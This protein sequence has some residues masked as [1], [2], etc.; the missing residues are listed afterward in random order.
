MRR[1]GVSGRGWAFRLAAVAVAAGFVLINTDVASR[2]GVM[3]GGDTPRY[4]NGADRL[5]A[6]DGLGHQQ[7]I[8]SGYVALV[9]L[10]DELRG[11][12][13]GVVVVQVVLAA[14]AALA[15]YDL[16]RCLAGRWVGLAAAALYVTSLDFTGFTGWHAYILTDS[17]YTSALAIATWAMHRASVRRGWWFVVGGLL[18]VC[19]A[20][21]RPQGWLLIPV[22]VVYSIAPRVT[23]G[24]ARLAV[25]WGVVAA[26]CALV[27]LSP[28]LSAN[29][30]DASP[31]RALRA[32]L[33]IYGST[34]WRTSMPREEPSGSRGW[35]DV[36]Y[37]AE[38][39]PV[40][41]AKTSVARVAAEVA[42][43]RPFYSAKRNAIILTYL[44]PLYTLALI[45]VA[46]RWRD[47][48][49]RLVATL[50]V[51]H[52]ALVTV[53]FADYD[54]RFLVHVLPLIGLLAALGG[55]WIASRVSTRATAAL[56]LR[57]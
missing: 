15:L 31:G 4:T 52:L 2:H 49:V 47:P 48:A 53:F 39:H 1:K 38:R 16:G 27:V 40:A 11:G 57:E 41:S 22:T 8:Y 17:S 35:G 36:A 33:V 45:G 6:G 44:I 25:G 23:G 10:V 51:L 14:L 5:L 13:G 32:G 50:V 43:V 19:A 46:I 3:L 42:H 18:V 34:D 54:G 12:L 29:T 24:W 9:A 21:L 30:A 26:F 20:S 7:R 55:S 56:P 37:Y 28:G